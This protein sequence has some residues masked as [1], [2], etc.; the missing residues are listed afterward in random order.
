MASLTD[1]TSTSD[2]GGIAQ[3]VSGVLSEEKLY[4]KFVI[5]GGPCAG[6]TTAME[7]LQVFL[8]ERGF[9]VF[10]V[11]EAATMLF[12]NGASPDDLARRECETAFQ[13]FVIKSQIQLEDSFMNYARSTGKKSVLLCDRGIMDGSAYVDDDIWVNVLS[14]VNLNVL[15]AREGRY[16]AVFHLVTAADGAT[17]FYSLVNNEAR[18]ETVEEAI[19]QDRK[20]QNAWNGHSQ[21]IVIDNRNGRAFERKMELL[22]SMLAGYVGLPSIARMSH[23]YELKSVPDLSLLPNVQVFDVEKIMLEDGLG[24]IAPQPRSRSGSLVGTIGTGSLTGTMEDTESTFD[25]RPSI[26][27]TGSETNPTDRVLYS[28]IRKR[29]QG[30]FSAYGLTTVKKLASGEKVELKRVINKS[31]YNIMASKADVREYV[32]MG[33]CRGHVVCL[34][35]WLY[36]W[37]Y[38]NM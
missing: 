38:G 15:S 17:P 14:S 36:L 7:R 27:S 25:R 4:Y 3:K 29:S 34:E 35:L 20:T 26:D 6:K 21:H 28:F 9:R 33:I 32:N 1:A 31:M 8:R 10:V 37:E 19:A 23:K 11:P 24:A 13:Q 30:G 5:T 12:I 22:V 16:D 18:H 2:S